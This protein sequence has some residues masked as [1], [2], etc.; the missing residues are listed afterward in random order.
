MPRNNVDPQRLSDAWRELFQFEKL[1]YI[2]KLSHTKKII[3]EAIS[4]SKSPTISWSGGK[5][6]TVVLHLVLQVFPNIPIIFVELDC[7]FPET[8]QYVIKLAKEWNLNL[9]IIKSKEHTFESVTKKYGYPI[10]SKN[11]ASNVER[12]I[13]TGNIR[14]QLSKF[15]VFLVQNKAHISSKCSQYLLERPCKIKEKELDCDLKFIGLRAL[16][17]RARVRLWADYGD[18]YPVKDYYGYNKP[19]LKCN[20]ISTWS[21]IDIWNYFKEYNIPI[22]DI[23]KKGYQRNGCWTCAMAIRNGQLQR[24]KNYRPDLYEDLLYNSEMGKEILR[25]KRLM[26]KE[27]EYKTYINLPE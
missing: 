11:I 22:C 26:D 12:A 8:K 5:D 16:E 3:N 17:S 18:L 4:Q 19:I 20:P 13:R 21:E 1:S 7:L 10:F 2:E 15:E 27:N 9:H 25:L 14:K 6:S 24:L 23:Y